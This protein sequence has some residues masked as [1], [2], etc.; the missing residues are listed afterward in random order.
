MPAVRRVGRSRTTAPGW[1]TSSARATPT[2]VASASAATIR[3]T[4]MRLVYRTSR[5]RG[6]AENRLRSATRV[7]DALE[8]PARHRDDVREALAQLPDDRRLEARMHLAVVAAGIFPALPVVPVDA[9]KEVLPARVVLPL[10]QVARPLP[11]LRRVRRVAPRRARIVAQPGRELEE[12]RRRR[13]LPVALRELDDA[14]E[15]RVDLVEVEEVVVARDRLVVIAGREEDAVDVEVGEERAHLLDLGDVGLAVDGRVR[16]DVVPALLALA[17]HGDRF[18][19]D[20]RAVH[21]VVVG[22]LHSVEMDVDRETLVGLR[23]LVE[24]IEEDRVRAH[25]DVLLP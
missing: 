24:A 15:L 8:L 18:V 11:A 16:A 5:A 1:S 25:D 14:T 12:E 22:L 21:D 10:D 7:A 19:E 9:A 6:D 4:G 23:L 2:H 3:R 13:D 20:A 17:D